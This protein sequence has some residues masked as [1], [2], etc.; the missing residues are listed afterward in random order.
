M[1]STKYIVYSTETT[2]AETTDEA[3]TEEEDGLLQDDVCDIV[4]QAG[5]AHTVIIRIEGDANVRLFRLEPDSRPRYRWD[6]RLE[7]E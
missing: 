3:K 2:R 4:Q 1:K 5:S 6:E 7:V